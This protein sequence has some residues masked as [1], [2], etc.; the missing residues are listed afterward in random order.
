M[1][2]KSLPD[3]LEKQMAKRITIPHDT[4]I[5]CLK[6]SVVKD[7][8]QKLVKRKKTDTE[9]VKIAYA[10]LK[11]EVDKA[12][13]QNVKMTTIRQKVYNINKELKKLGANRQFVAHR[14]KG[15]GRAPADYSGYLFGV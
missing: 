10:T 13:G 4:F 12:I 3:T 8:Q 6:A 7:A 11:K 15:T 2:Q 14:E 9:K 1:L 5:A